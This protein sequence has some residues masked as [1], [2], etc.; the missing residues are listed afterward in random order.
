[1]KKSICAFFIFTF[2]IAF[3]SARYVEV[4]SE[5]PEKPD[6]SGYTTIFMGTLD[7]PEDIWKT[8]GY[9]SKEKWR[10]VLDDLNSM[11][12][13]IH[14]ADVAPQKK[15]IA[16]VNG[17]TGEA[18][19]YVKLTYKGFRKNTGRA[20]T[21]KVDTLD[22]MVTMYDNKT[23]K[24]LSKATQGAQS[25]GAHKRGWMMNAFEGRLDNQIYNLCC[26]IAGKF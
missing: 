14:M 11:K 21:H 15:I 25:T 13:K 20:F 12:L 17:F 2:S 7:M 24:Q 10:P 4:V 19:V 16:P 6:L 3:A 23:R 18:G 9:S 1:M 8:F 26:F 22:V 5:S